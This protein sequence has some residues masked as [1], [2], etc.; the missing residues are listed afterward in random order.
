MDYLESLKKKASNAP[1]TSGMFVIELH[2]VSH[3]N[4]WVLDIDWGSHICTDMQGLRNSRKLSKGES[5]LHVGNGVRVATLALRT[6]VLTLPSGLVLHLNDCFYVPPL[7][8]NIISISYLNMKGF[9]VTFSNNGCSIMLNGVLYS[10]GTLC[11]D[12]YILDMSNSILT[13]D[14][15]KRQKQDNLKSSYS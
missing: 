6:Y 9:H 14:D 13:I 3:D 12:I 10:I 8:K 7:K 4:L 11:N 5:N 1:S 15:N 2:I